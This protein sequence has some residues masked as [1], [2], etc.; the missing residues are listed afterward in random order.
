[1]HHFRKKGALIGS[2]TS[3]RVLYLLSRNSSF[4]RQDKKADYG[5]RL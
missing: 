1:M 5:L 2:E 3:L 4:I